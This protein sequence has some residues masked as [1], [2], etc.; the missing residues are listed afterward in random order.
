MDYIKHVR[1]P[2]HGFIGITNIE[3]SV[4]D[5][6][7]FQ[8]LRYIKQLG[9]VNLIY[10][11][12]NHTRFEHSLGVMH[13]AGI[14]GAKMDCDE[15]EIQNLRLAGLLHDIGHGPFSHSFENA[16]SLVNREKCSHEKIGERIIREHAP[17]TEA[18]GDRT[19][20]ITELLYEDENYLGKIISSDLDVD[21]MDYLLRDSHH[22]GVK[23]GN[24]DID[25]IMHCI[26]HKEKYGQHYICIEEKG[27]YAIEN[28]RLARLSMFLQV[29][30]HKTVNIADHMINRAIVHSA[31]EG[32]LKNTLKLNNYDF[33]QRFLELNDYSLMS[34]LINDSND[35]ARI[36]ARK[37][38]ER[39]LLKEVY[40]ENIKN[41]SVE[42]RRALMNLGI[43]TLHKLESKIAEEISDESCNVIL[44]TWKFINKSYDLP[45]NE[46]EQIYIVGKDGNIKQFAD[47]MI[48]Q[49]AKD[50][51]EYAT[52]M[53]DKKLKP[54]FTTKNLESIFNTTINSSKKGCVVF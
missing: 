15:N 41:F 23:Y 45:S 42:H 17:L 16:I 9:N 32:D 2:I 47:D 26:L 1:D 33:V 4:I 29:Y 40:R 48:I 51:I 44:G 8:R 19:E 52:I 35:R 7:A 21:R 27:R 20:S 54:G 22:V 24:Y 13:L 37:F 30:Q 6:P 3:L 36:M 14:F 39:N 5:T 49:S 10:P 11:S 25:R 12:A 28:F 43:D 34:S 18:L 31:N 53:S 46:S 38:F 50:R